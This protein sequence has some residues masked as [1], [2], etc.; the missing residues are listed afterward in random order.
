MLTIFPINK[1]K[2][3]EAIDTPA[4]LCKIRAKEI[5][6]EKI[7]E[8]Q[9]DIAQTV[10]YKFLKQQYLRCYK[11]SQDQKFIAYLQF[12]ETNFRTDYV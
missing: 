1:G 5:V 10:V 3:L 9:L 11:V 4:P 8:D 6:E 12:L 2:I 7:T